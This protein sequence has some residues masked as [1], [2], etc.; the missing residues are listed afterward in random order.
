MAAP[1]KYDVAISFLSGDEP[2]ALELHERLSPQLD[3]FVYSKKQEAIAGTD[4]LETFRQVFRSNSRLVVVLY[5]DGWGATPWTRVEETAIKDRALQEGWDWLLFVM[6]DATSTPPKW[7]PESNVRL[8]LPAYGLDQ[9]V[10]AIKVRAQ[11]VGSVFRREDAVERAK[12]LEQRTAARAA[13][14][15]LLHSDAGVKA[16]QEAVHALYVEVDRLVAGIREQSPKLSVD[17]GIQNPRCVI[18]T[19]AASV[20]LYWHQRYANT[21]NDSGLAV[22]EFAGRVALPG[23]EGT[24]IEE[25]RELSEALY[26]FDVTPDLGS[27]WRSQEGDRHLTSVE[28]ADHCV[29]LLLKLTEL[30]DAGDVE[31]PMR[32]WERALRD[33]SGRSN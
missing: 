7:L 25:P 28:L 2:L 19:G 23:R 15:Q 29:S 26:V 8:S 10:G 22:R 11:G 24:V 31:R 16:A 32:P 13:R 12:R 33:R 14:E 20:T 4:G 1:A 17:V 3:V 9:V 5:R 27:C 30:V 18:T 6:L 21:L